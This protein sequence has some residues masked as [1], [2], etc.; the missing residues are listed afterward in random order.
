[1]SENSN[2]KFSQVFSIP[3]TNRAQNYKNICF[4]QAKSML[5]SSISLKLNTSSMFIL[6]KNPKDQS[7]IKEIS[8][9]HPFLPQKTKSIGIVQNP[10]KINSKNNNLLEKISFFLQ[11]NPS[12]T[13]LHQNT[14]KKFKQKS[15]LP[16]LGK[17][18]F[19]LNSNNSLKVSKLNPMIIKNFFFDKNHKLMKNKSQI[20]K[21]ITDQFLIPNEF[22]EEKPE[23]K[24]KIKEEKKGKCKRKII[25]RKEKT[26]GNLDFLKKIE[27]SFAGTNDENPEQ[28]DDFVA[29]VRK[30]KK[31]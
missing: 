19:D 8:F 9:S 16:T 25:N 5:S 26:E 10:Q 23:R 18:K 15:R 12:Q 13:I 22:V 21:P 7:S 11:N 24:I 2:L 30:S 14:F 29:Y 6:K 28:V 20:I 4:L 1:M 3:K 27:N 17:E 31:L